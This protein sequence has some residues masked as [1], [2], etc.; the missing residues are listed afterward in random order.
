M[1]LFPL[2]RQSCGRCGSGVTV[3]SDLCGGCGHVLHAPERLRAAGALYLALGLLLT[4]AAGHLLAAVT[5]AVIRP[6]GSL[7]FSG[8]AWGLVL[9]YGS[10][11]FVLTLGVTGLL[12]GAWQLAY[13]RR[14]LK[15][16]R[17]VTV[18]YII[19]MAAALAIR[20]LF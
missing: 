17:V 10:L 5:R 6:D 9:A 20:F 2:A 13:G 12:M 19:F 14:N 4:S 7:R 8:G 18:I 16:V 15:M 3:W 1:I 11:G